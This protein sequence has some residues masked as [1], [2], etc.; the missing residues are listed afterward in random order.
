MGRKRTP[1]ID[2]L[3]ITLRYYAEGCYQRSTGDNDGHPQPGVSRA[4]RIISRVIA[5]LLPRFIYS[6][7]EEGRKRI[8][9]GLYA[10]V[11]ER[12]PQAR[13]FP[14][15]VGC[16]DCTQINFLAAGVP[17]REFFRNRHGEIAINV[18]AIVA[19]LHELG[20]QVAGERA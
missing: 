14:Q 20:S 16:I 12:F 19:Q 1:L 11:K 9:G 5:Q 3:L 10:M 6:P 4:I 18:Q 8:A 7:D 13:G 17:N 2:L 15:V